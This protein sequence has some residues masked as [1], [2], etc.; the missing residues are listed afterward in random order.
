MVVAQTL[1]IDLDGVIRTWRSQDDP[2]REAAFGLPP[3]AIRRVAFTPER[4]MPAITGQISD[5]VWR[6]QITAELA[7]QFPHADTASAMEWWSSSPGEVVSEVVDLVRAFRTYGRVVLVTNAT[8]R[9]PDDLRRLEL[10]ALFDQVV[11]SAVV[12]VAKPE[13]AIFAA[14]LMAAGVAAADA[15]FV[16]DLPA[17]V[18]AAQALGIRAH[19]YV[20]VEALRL[21]LLA[22]GAI[23]HR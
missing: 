2:E 18:A 5:P 20:S 15:L 13:P 3:G 21:A 19:Q 16:D 9:L 22:H 14:A 4:V 17:N 11:N 10:T 23:G 1:L 6:D 8:T 12:G 7:R